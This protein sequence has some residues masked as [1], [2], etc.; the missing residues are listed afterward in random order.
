MR[1]KMSVTGTLIVTDLEP[2]FQKQHLSLC[3]NFTII[4]GA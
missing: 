4:S 3:H 2:E 1:E